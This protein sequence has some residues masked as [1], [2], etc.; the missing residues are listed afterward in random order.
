MPEEKKK[1]KVH[2]G[3]GKTPGHFCVLPQRAV[4]DIRF[5]KHPSIFRVLAALG[6]YTSRQGVCW[7]NQITIARDLHITQS[8][9][10]K[11]IKKLMEW[12]Y[13]RYA[14]KHP[15]LRG[16]K[17]FMVFDPKIS[18]DDAIATATVTD[19]SFEEKPEVKVHPKSKED[20]KPNQR[21]K[22]E[23]SSKGITDRKKDAPSAYVDIHSEGLRNN[24]G[25]SSNIYLK[26]IEILNTFIKLTEEIFGQHKQYDMKQ[27]K[28]VEDW[29]NQ[30]LHPPTAIAKIKQ[31]IEWRRDNHKDAPATIYFFKD[32]IN[33]V[34][35]PR[36]KEEQVKGILKKITRKLKMRY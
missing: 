7:P 11:H 31:I 19:R 6:N 20:E 24:I 13:V 15:G 16:N 2:Y 1:S 28:V 30:G 27:V 21:G 22:K 3:K 12:D 18:E 35:R 9:I 29:I 8:T 34:N 26:A 5:K 4:I 32:A 10:S 23:Y 25:N 14:K 17:Y 33:K 36:N